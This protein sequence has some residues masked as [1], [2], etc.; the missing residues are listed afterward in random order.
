[1]NYPTTI[2]EWFYRLSPLLFAAGAAF[3]ITSLMGSLVMHRNRAVEADPNQQMIAPSKQ[4][5]AWHVVHIPDD[6]GSLFGALSI[7]NALLAAILVFL[8]FR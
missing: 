8:M 4:V 7:T 5:M 2:A 6:I 1:M 3:F